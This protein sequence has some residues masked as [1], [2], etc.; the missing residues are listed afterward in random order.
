[1]SDES[2]KSCP[3]CG[4]APKVRDVT[5]KSGSRFYCVICVNM[6]CAIKPKTGWDI[7]IDDVIKQW[8]FRNE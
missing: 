1:M 3:F 8:N 2:L 4:Y 5:L 6:F 7:N